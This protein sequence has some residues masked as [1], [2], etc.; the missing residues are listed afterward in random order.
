MPCDGYLEPPKNYLLIRDHSHTLVRGG[1]WMQK[2][3][4]CD[5]FLAPPRDLKKFQGPPFATKMGQPHRKACKLNFYWKICGNFFKP[6][7]LQMSKNLRAPLF[8]SGP[9]TS[10][11]ELSLRPKEIWL[12]AI[13]GRPES[14]KLD[15][16]VFTVQKYTTLISKF[17]I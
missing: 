5:F 14:W 4:C 8:A 13:T 6:P 9:L 7:P 12:F 3:N 1:G 11:C 15:K 2:E 17:W 10:V 16:K